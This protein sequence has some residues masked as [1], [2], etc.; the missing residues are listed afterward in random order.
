M[1]SDDGPVSPR[2]QRQR[3]LGVTSAFDTSAEGSQ[4]PTPLEPPSLTSAHAHDVSSTSLQADTPAGYYSHEPLPEYS[5]AVVH[6][7]NFA[8]HQ[9]LPLVY[10]TDVGRRGLGVYIGGQLLHI[11]TSILVDFKKSIIQDQE[12]VGGCLKVGTFTEVLFNLREIADARHVGHNLQL[13]EDEIGKLNERRKS[14]R[15]KSPSRERQDKFDKLYHDGEKHRHNRALLRRRKE[16]TATHSEQNHIEYKQHRVR[17]D[18]PEAVSSHAKEEIIETIRS[19]VTAAGLPWTKKRRDRCLVLYGAFDFASHPSRLG[20]L[21]P[22]LAKGGRKQDAAENFLV[23][24]DDGA[25]EYWPRDLLTFLGASPPKATTDT[26][27]RLN[28]YPKHEAIEKPLPKLSERIN[29]IHGGNNRYEV[30]AG[31]V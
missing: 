4:P 10:R 11:A 24:F 29:D 7:T 15:T 14:R 6:V 12:G 23:D 28:F 27:S 1:D 5:E 20:S 19:A 8:G 18:V 26:Y 31:N 30:A 17:L 25:T 13:L 21:S 16:A 3:H 9:L 2:E 22:N